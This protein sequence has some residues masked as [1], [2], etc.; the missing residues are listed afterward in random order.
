M[1][2]IIVSETAHPAGESKIALA[3]AA[4]SELVIDPPGGRHRASFD[5]EL[6]CHGAGSTKVAGSGSIGPTHRRLAAPPT[7]F[8]DAQPHRAIF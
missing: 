8:P 6:W 4:E 1:H 7:L 3:T 2:R 5:A